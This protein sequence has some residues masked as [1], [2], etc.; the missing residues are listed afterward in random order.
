MKTLYFIGGAMGVGKTTTARE[1]KNLL[2]SCVMLDGDN[3]WDMDPFIVDDETKKCV[4]SNIVAC[5]SNFLACPRFKNIIF[6]WVL[7]KREIA[8][9]ILS[10]LELEGVRVLHI[11]LICSERTLLK[12]LDGDIAAGLRKEDVRAR[13]AAYLPLYASLPAIKVE[14]DGLTPREAA[15]AIA[16]L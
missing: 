4:V 10:R 11:S 3:L 5:L 16:A 13:A 14:T 1:L 8:D 7:H 6:C 12:R 15:E 2:P 9:Y